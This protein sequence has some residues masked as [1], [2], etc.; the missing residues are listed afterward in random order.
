M[1]QNFQT[2]CF[3]PKMVFVVSLEKNKI[4]METIVLLFLLLNT[5]ILSHSKQLQLRKNDISPSSTTTKRIGLSV[6]TIPGVANCARDGAATSDYEILGKHNAITPAGEHVTRFY[7]YL[8]YSKVGEDE[9]EIGE[10]EVKTSVPSRCS[11]RIHGEHHVGGSV[12]SQGTAPRELDVVYDCRKDTKVD[13]MLTIPVVGHAPVV[14]QWTKACDRKELEDLDVSFVKSLPLPSLNNGSMVVSAGK[15]SEM[16]ENASNVFSGRALELEFELL[17]KRT[18]PSDSVFR[19]VSDIKV[20]ANPPNVIP[21]TYLL[22]KDETISL[23]NPN[24]TSLLD[25][26][27]D[28]GQETILCH[29]HLECLAEGTTEIVLKIRT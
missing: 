7:V 29:V 11:A 3:P 15:V 27:A 8:D 16:W 21:T 26:A 5:I 6:G 1:F 18:I 22:F 9:A 25:S 14:L 12:Y 10:A 28:Q 2:F 23:P 4:N 13:V 24:I 17:S 20:S 19:T